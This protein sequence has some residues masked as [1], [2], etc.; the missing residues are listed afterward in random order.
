MSQ[1]SDEV[2]AP[3]AEDGSEG[4]KLEGDTRY[5]EEFGVPSVPEAIFEQDEAAET[6]PQQDEAT[7]PP[8]QTE[9]ASE[10]GNPEERE[11]AAF[12]EEPAHEEDSDISPLQPQ[13]PMQMETPSTALLTR[14]WCL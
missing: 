12:L 8:T 4:P 14:R 5:E 7:L 13:Q 10:E 1:S 3:A 6:P 9:E 11:A 2:E